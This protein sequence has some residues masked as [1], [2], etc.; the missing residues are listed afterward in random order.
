MLSNVIKCFT[1][2]LFLNMVLGSCTDHRQGELSPNRLRLKRTISTYPGFPGTTEFAYDG[3]GRE[4]GFTYGNYIG[5]FTYNSRGQVATYI[6]AGPVSSVANGYTT[7][8][9]DYNEFSYSSPTNLTVYNGPLVAVNGNYVSDRTFARRVYTYTLD[10]QSRT[11]SQYNTPVSAGG[12][13][14]AT[15]DYTYSGDNIVKEAN[16]SC[17]RCTPST[18]AYQFDDKSN[19]FYGLIG[20]GITEV[21]RSSRHN[22]IR[23]VYA[24]APQPDQETVI[25]Y[26][27]NAQGYPTKATSSGGEVRFEYERY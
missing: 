16:R 20:P 21:R 19:P 1:L 6:Y 2:L 23:S 22:V 14:L 26:E 17:S 7:Y 12:Q 4:S 5:S 18:T 13:D 11:L 25:S 15:S 3:A 8:E 9:G 24:F 10:G 27:Y